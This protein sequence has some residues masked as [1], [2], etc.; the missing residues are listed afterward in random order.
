MG[1]GKLYD[2][3]VFEL[4]DIYKN[5]TVVFTCYT[6]NTTYGFRH[7]ATLGYNDTIDA[8]YIKSDI[9]GKA[10]Y[11]NRTWECYKYQTVLKRAISNTDID[12]D[13]KKQLLDIVEDY[14]L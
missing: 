10:S 9:V 13:S 14:I 12:K 6:Q 1:Y 3:K 5:K 4:K 8:K 2:R 11:Y 7:I